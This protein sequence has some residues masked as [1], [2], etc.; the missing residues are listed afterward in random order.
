MARIG[1]ISGPV[2]HDFQAGVDMP[3]LGVR[4]GPA[5]HGVRTVAQPD[6]APPEGTAPLLGR[7]HVGHDG[8]GVEG[9]PARRPLQMSPADQSLSEE[10]VE[11]QRG[12][13]VEG[14]LWTLTTLRAALGDVGSDEDGKNLCELWYGK[15]DGSFMMHQTTTDMRGRRAA[16]IG[17]FGPF[18]GN[19]YVA[20]KVQ[21][22]CG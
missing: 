1:G 2:E 22:L 7:A 16:D 17:P 19:L 5:V 8:Q 13:P 9:A 20:I 18:S 21:N 6:S 4:A 14:H 15:Y 10:S 11:P 12:G 3:D